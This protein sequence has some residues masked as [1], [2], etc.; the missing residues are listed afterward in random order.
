[1]K[2][3]EDEYTLALTPHCFMCQ[4]HCLPPVWTCCFCTLGRGV[5]RDFPDNQLRR[6]SEG[7]LAALSGIFQQL[8][9]R[10]IVQNGRRIARLA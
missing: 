9:C 3:L 7:R 8:N 10:E 5:D 2:A 1:M 6:L 4:Q